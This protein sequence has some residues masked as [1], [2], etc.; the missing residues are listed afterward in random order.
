MHTTSTP[1]SGGQPGGQTAGAGTENADAFVTSAE[2]A[3]MASPPVTEQTVANWRKR[4]ENFPKPDNFCNGQ[5]L[6][7]TNVIRQWLDA[8]QNARAVK[9][10]SFLNLKGGVGKTTL[11][12]NLAHIFATAARRV[13]LVDFDPQFNASQIVMGADTYARELGYEQS[14]NPTSGE[15]PPQKR[16]GTT[17]DI[18]E[19]S[20]AG[21][22]SNPVYPL[23]ENIRNRYQPERKGCLHIIPASL[24]LAKTLRNPAGKEM[25]LKNFLKRHEENYDYIFIDCSPTDSM[26]AVAAYHASDYILVPMKPE[27]LS[28]I[29][30]HLL[31]SSVEEFKKEF[32]ESKLRILGVCFNHVSKA[33]G[34]Y[35]RSK[36][37]VARVCRERDIYL[38]EKEISF[39]ESYAKGAREGTPIYNTSYARENKITNFYHF[40]IEFSHELKSPHAGY[41]ERPEANT[42][43]KGINTLL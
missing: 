10:I 18:M 13:L 26:L 3:G 39:S 8:T 28:T 34:E 5:P 16:V 36:R 37:H 20:T 40:A 1:A 27:F 19:S 23:K 30:L 24:E 31:I 9:V 32:P 38:F 22:I 4:F 7:R 12:V 17:F 6:W 35:P 25:R 29:G 43:D 14:G 2:I 21:D 41:E 11:A 42:E 15:P 33:Q